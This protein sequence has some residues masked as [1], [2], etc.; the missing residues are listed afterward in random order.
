MNRL[1]R[2]AAG[3]CTAVAITVAAAGHAQGMGRRAPGPSHR[4]KLDLHLRAAL[5]GNSTRESHRVII[6]VAPGGQAALRGLLAGHG[7]ALVAEHESSGA[8]RAGVYTEDLDALAGQ[9]QIISV[10]SDAVV[11]AKLLGGLL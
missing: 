1:F 5:D 8:L 2:K 3:I 4:D 11:R 9:Q 10:S 7:D 6:R